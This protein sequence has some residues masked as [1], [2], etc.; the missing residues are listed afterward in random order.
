MATEPVKPKVTF[1]RIKFNLPWG[2]QTQTTAKKALAP[3]LAARGSNMSFSKVRASH[4]SPGIDHIAIAI[5]LK[6]PTD[7]PAILIARVVGIFPLAAMTIAVDV[8][9]ENDWAK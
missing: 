7:A 5:K 8:C 2:T 1:T 3:I 9:P 6:D 4:N